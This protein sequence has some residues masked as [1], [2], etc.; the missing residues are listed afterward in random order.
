MSEANHL[1]NSCPA[2]PESFKTKRTIDLST[3]VME[4]THFW[5]LSDL[6]GVE[7]GDVFRKL[8]DLVGA[9]VQLHHRWPGPDV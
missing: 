2:E 6:K 4:W 5:S 9:E 8:V 7:Q 3:Q 1:P